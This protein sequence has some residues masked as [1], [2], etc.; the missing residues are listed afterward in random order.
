MK[1]SY[2]N[3]A[4]HDLKYKIA[5]S[6]A[7]QMDICSKDVEKLSKETGRQVVQQ[8]CILITGAT[9][10][11]PNFSA[12][13]AKEAGGISIGFSPAASEIAHVK[14]Y[15]LPL[16]CYDVMVYTGFDYSGRN[17]LMT[18]AADGVIII[19]GR[20]GTLNEFTIAYEDGKPIGILEGSGGTADLVKELLKKPHR[21][22]A[23]VVFEKNPQKLVKKLIEVIKKEKGRK[24]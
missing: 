5:V 9:T 24:I 10:G 17:L 2:I 21:K 3:I 6:G 4:H 20:M 19:C 14:T 23:E 11:C 16:E 8:G 13:G 1:K 18:R 12:Q 15:K 7:S 22:G